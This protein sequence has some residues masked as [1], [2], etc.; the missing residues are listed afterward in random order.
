[1]IVHKHEPAELPPA[2]DWSLY[3]KHP[4]NTDLA[5][6]DEKAA[7]H[8]YEGFGRDEGRV[9]GAIDGRGTFLGLIPPSASLLEIGPFCTPGFTSHTHRVRYLD[10]FP[11]EELRRIVGGLSWGKPDLVPEIDYVWRGEPYAQLIG[12]RFDAVFSSHNIEHQPCLVTHLRDV[13]S[14][15]K[16]GRRMFLIISDRR[17]CFN[18]YL[19]ESTIAEVLDAFLDNR[20]RQH[21]ARSILEHRLLLTHN[22]AEPHWNGDHGPDPRRAA[23]DGDTVRRIIENL[24]TLPARDGYVDTHAWQ[25][26]PDSFAQLIGTLNAAGLTPFEVERVYPTLRLSNEFFAVLRL[27]PAPPA[28]GSAA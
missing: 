3:V 4:Q 15:L 1:M 17:Y 12:E 11:T 10:A 27:P 6:F 23:P 13:A 19:A 28:D 22:E 21:S 8:H 5:G 26:V 2:F 24:K 25:F 20:R 16:P 7:T 18:Y 14:V 9:C